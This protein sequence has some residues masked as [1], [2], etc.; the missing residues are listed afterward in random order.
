MQSPW[1]HSPHLSQHIM[2]LQLQKVPKPAKTKHFFLDGGLHKQSSQ[3]KV[4]LVD[5][6]HTSQYRSANFSVLTWEMGGKRFVGQWV[7][8]VLCQPDQPHYQGSGAEAVMHTNIYKTCSSS[9]V[10]VLIFIINGMSVFFNST[11]NSPLGFCT[12]MPLP[13]KLEQGW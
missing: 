7:I 10:A 13:P 3:S 6:K 4:W 2:N 9:H 5:G 12:R 1:Y 8:T 11:I